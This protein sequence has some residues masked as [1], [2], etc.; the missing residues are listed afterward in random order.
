MPSFFVTCAKNLE[1]LLKA[2]IELIA[3]E[4]KLQATLKETVAGVHVTGPLAL[5]YRL[6]L[7]SRLANQVF[8]PLTQFEATNPEDLYRE[9]KRIEWSTHLSP[10]GTLWIDVTGSHA[11]FNHPHFV[12]QKIKDAIVDQLRTPDGKRPT[13]QE[14]RPDIVVNLHMDK[15]L[16]TLSLSLSGESLHKRGYRLEGGKA[17]LKETLAAA[18]LMRAGWL[19]YLQ[20]PEPHHVFLDPMCGTGTLLI[21]AALMAFDIAPG[22]GRHYFGFLR[23]LPHDKRLWDELLAEAAARKNKGLMNDHV[24]FFGSDIHPHAIEKTLEN[25]ARAQLSDRFSILSQHCGDLKRP[26][27][28]PLP[29]RGFI[30]CNPPYGERM[31]S[32]EIEG[33]KGLFKK[34]GEAL[35]RECL[36]WQLGVFFGGPKETLQAMKLRSKK[37]Y[38]LFNGT[39][40]CQLFMYDVSE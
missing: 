1:S 23:W 21:E 13:I 11:R 24:H 3:G 15:G 27:V 14:T 35:K 7:W 8:L 32:E 9:V 19:T 40:P 38:S 36:G 4:G 29:S 2:E 33:L 20:S 5:G 17:P 34:F 26:S 12:A 31:D 6:C 22:L 18:I 37:Q 28:S 39:L 16:C 30:V 25:S 10:E